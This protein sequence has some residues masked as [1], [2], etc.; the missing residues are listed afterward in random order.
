MY[1]V[2]PDGMMATPPGWVKNGKNFIYDAN[3]NTQKDAEAIYGKESIAIEDG[4]TIKGEGYNYSMNEGGRVTNNGEYVNINDGITSP[5]GYTISRAKTESDTELDTKAIDKVATAAGTGMAVQETLLKTAK[6]TAQHAD[7]FSGVADDILKGTAILGKAT[8][9][10]S[11]VTAW[12][13]Y[14]N[15][16]TTGGLIKAVANTGLALAKTNPAVGIVTGIMDAT[17]VSDKIYN[18]AGEFIDNQIKE[19]NVITH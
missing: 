12:I 7:D 5:G 6:S 1:F 4:A 13:D 8:G 15:N 2:D 16:P 17:G 11:A 10:T 9:I 18:S 14:S 19:N 3:V